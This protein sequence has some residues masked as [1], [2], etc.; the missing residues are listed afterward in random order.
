M[1]RHAIDNLQT[2]WVKL[3]HEVAQ[4][5]LAAGCNDFGGTLMEES[6]SREAGADAGEYTSAE[7][8]AALVRA[9]D[10]TP[11]ERTTLYRRRS[12]AAIHESE[13][14]RADDRGP[15]GWRGRSPLPARIGA[16]H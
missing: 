12:S 4:L 7:D 6:I 16:G 11:V 3:G 13:A 10:R 2:S 14:A 5:S 1:L 8:I 9:A 15:G